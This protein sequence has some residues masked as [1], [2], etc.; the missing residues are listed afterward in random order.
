RGA[1]IKV[2]FTKSHYMQR[3][4]N[5]KRNLGEA[6]AITINAETFNINARLTPAVRLSGRVTDEVTHAGIGSV[7]VVITDSTT[8][9]CPFGN[10]TVGVTNAD[11]VYAFPVPKNTPLKIQFFPFGSA[12]P[13]Y[14]SEWFDDQPTWDTAAIRSFSVDTAGI[15]AMLTRGFYIS[16]HVFDAATGAGLAGINIAGSDALQPCCFG[17]AFAT[18][19]ANGD[20]RMLAR[21][22]TYRIRFGDPN[23]TYAPQF[24]NNRPNSDQ[25]DLVTTGPDRPNINAALSRGVTIRGHVADATGTVPVAGINVNVFDAT[26]PCCVFLGG[27]MT[28]AAGNYTAFPSHGGPVK[29]SFAKFGPIPPGTRWLGQWYSGKDSFDAADTVNAT[30]VVSG[31]DARLATGFLISGHVSERGTGTA[32]EGIFVE[33]VRAAIPCCPFSQAAFTQTDAFGNYAAVVTAG[34]YKIQFQ[35]GTRRHA[36]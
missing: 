31:I 35:D 34:D 12:D 36:D 6:D 1:M 19:D 22:G 3:W 32:L 9:C 13:R 23:G 27:G 15:D 29:V 26:V 7:A 17:V 5:E 4:W 18:T 8:R 20:Y 10:I 16:G 28:D 33:V 30:G 14:I 25:A 2:T 11:G 24:W 21:P